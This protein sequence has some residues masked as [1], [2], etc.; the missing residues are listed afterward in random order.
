MQW[1]HMPS[2]SHACLEH[3]LEGRA[4]PSYLG[5][6]LSLAPKTHSHATRWRKQLDRCISQSWRLLYCT[7]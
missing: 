3:K 4:Q 1:L 2:D 5:R 7:M 6:H